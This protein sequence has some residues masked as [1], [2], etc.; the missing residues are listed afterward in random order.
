MRLQDLTV[1]STLRHAYL[2][3]ALAPEL[4][5]AP[6][7]P[8]DSFQKRVLGDVNVRPKKTVQPCLLALQR[9]D[10]APR[11]LVIDVKVDER[12]PPNIAT[13]T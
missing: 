9:S 11:Q 6:A 8:S 12:D 2:L 10:A 13:S 3:A 5:Q 4:F 7:E 1:A